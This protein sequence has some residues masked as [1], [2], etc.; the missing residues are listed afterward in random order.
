LVIFTVDHGIEMP[1]AKFTL[2]EPGLHVPL[3]LRWPAGG[4]FG[5]KVYSHLTGNVDVL[6]SLL[7]LLGLPS[8]PK[9]EGVSFAKGLS[10]ASGLP[11]REYVY[12]AQ[13]GSD[14]RSIRDERY[15]LIRNFAARRPFSPP[16]DPKT[17]F[18][19]NACCP[20][21]ELY[22]L[23]NDPNEF[24]NVAEC[25]EYA[26]V[27]NK[28]DAALWNT[29]YKLDDPIFRGAT[30]HRMWVESM[31]ECPLSSFKERKTRTI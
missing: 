16:V 27:R 8:E 23:Q 2:Y 20:K 18:V 29:M 14:A 10:S 11:H 24:N 6:P 7:E 1:R 25:P 21:V 13:F 12:A 3:I 15:K 30:P 9:I 17:P 5:G 28:L 26:E 19:Q 4:I 31:A 22:D